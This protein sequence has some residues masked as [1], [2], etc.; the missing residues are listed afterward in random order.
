MD[1]NSREKGDKIHNS[2]AFSYLVS[3]DRYVKTLIG[4]RQVTDVG[5][6]GVRQTVRERHFFKGDH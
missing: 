6:G 2:F 4:H 1:I 5:Y 3:L